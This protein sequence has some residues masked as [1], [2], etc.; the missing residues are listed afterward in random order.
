MNVSEYCRYDAIGLAELVRNGEVS[1]KDVAETSARAIE[2]VNPQL[3]A[4]IEIFRDRVQGLE[5]SQLQNGPF[6]GVPFLM[7][8]VG[9]SVK[10]RKHEQGSRLMEGY[11]ADLDTEFTRRVKQAGFNIM[12][13]TTCPEF[14]STFTT[15]SDLYGATRNPWNLDRI[16]G[17]SSGG[18]AAI[19]AAGGVPISNANDGGGS[20]RVPASICGNVGLKHSRGRVSQAPYGCSLSFPL[21]DEGVNARSVRDVAAFLDVTQGSAPG[22]AT[23][24]SDVN[25][26]FQDCLHKSQDKLRIAVTIDAWGEFNM[27]GGAAKEV[28]RVASLCTDLGHTVEFLIPP[29]DF[30]KFRLA[31][32]T[33][34]KVDISV[35]IDFAASEVG[36]TVSLDTLESMTFKLYQSAQNYSGKDR[37]LANFDTNYVSRELGEFFE[38]FDLI[39]TPTVARKTPE[40]GSDIRLGANLPLDEWL[41]LLFTLCPYAPLCNVTG[42][43]AISLPLGKW[44][45]GMPLGMHF[46]AP[47][48]RE[49]R[50]LG[51]ARS[52]EEAAPWNDERPPVYVA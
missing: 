18:C 19:V 9:Q 2:N 14:G 37:T 46:I 27:D 21:F 12:G 8:D 17:G 43:P 13:R 20:T 41:Q 36:K 7:K 42:L 1:P 48:G 49:D 16:T 34:Y 5:N 3:N 10:G 52:L 30:N 47:M 4:V 28:Q 40:I 15:E 23:C 38:T 50:L 11:V 26:S 33:I 22:A 44:E 51:I 24:S 25:Y 6:F 29:I 45:D 39:L 35:A 32:Q 31:W